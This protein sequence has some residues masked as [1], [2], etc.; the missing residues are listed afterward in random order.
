MA[1]NLH[2]HPELARASQDVETA[3]NREPQNSVHYGRG[4]AANVARMSDEAKAGARERNEKRRRS[5]ATGVVGQFGRE[6]K[7][8]EKE[9]EGAE[10][11][12]GKGK[13]LV[14]KGFAKLTRVMSS[15]GQP[16][17]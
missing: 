13:N 7:E 12:K 1:L 14:E 10:N 17:K 3:P 2:S 9:K 8:K 11:D 6:T 16:N 5:E 15:N 4:G